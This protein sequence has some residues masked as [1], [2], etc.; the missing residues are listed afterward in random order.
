MVTGGR[1]RRLHTMPARSP[2]P[3]GLDRDPLSRN[4][5]D[6]RVTKGGGMGEHASRSWQQYDVSVRGGQR[7]VVTPRS[8]EPARYQLDDI[9]KGRPRVDIAKVA[10]G[11]VALAL[12]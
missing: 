11:E 9:G 6:G 8:R 5:E 1:D 10:L 12:A 2:R 4:T 7:E 3:H